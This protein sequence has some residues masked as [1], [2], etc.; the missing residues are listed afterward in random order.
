MVKLQTPYGELNFPDESFRDSWIAGRD[1]YEREYPCGSG[2]CS[3]YALS[4]LQ[5]AGWIR[6][7]NGNT[8]ARTGA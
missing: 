4:G 6:E 8:S 2:S 7:A 1:L 3:W 5:Q